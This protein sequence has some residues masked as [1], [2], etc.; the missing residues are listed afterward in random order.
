MICL[1]MFLLPDVENSDSNN[2]LQHYISAI[3][4]CF[5]NHQALF[6]GFSSLLAYG[7]QSTP[8][9]SFGCFRCRNLDPTLPIVGIL[10]AGYGVL[11]IDWK[12]KNIWFLLAIANCLFCL[13]VCACCMLNEKCLSLFY[14]TIVFHC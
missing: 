13:K 8:R 1:E 11:L 12:E 6:W 9:K 3:R 2:A 10:F 14:W 4:W 5:F 7:S